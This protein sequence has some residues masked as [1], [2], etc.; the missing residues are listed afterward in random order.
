MMPVSQLH[1]QQLA[2][3]W[4]SINE[5]VCNIYKHAFRIACWVKVQQS[6][7]TKQLQNSCFFLSLRLHFTEKAQ[8]VE[9]SYVNWAIVHFIDTSVILFENTSKEYTGGKKWPEQFW[10]ALGK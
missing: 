6:Q 5:L 9:Y 7:I 1:V 3:P 2:W 8:E 4:Q 10:L